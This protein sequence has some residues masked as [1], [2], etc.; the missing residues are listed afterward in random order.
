MHRINE[1]RLNSNILDWNFIP[2]K[3]NIS[4]ICTRPLKI[5]EFLNNRYYLTGPN[6]LHE[7]ISFELNDSKIS[8]DE[9]KIEKI[10]QV[11]YTSNTVFKPIISWQNYSSWIKLI[12]YVSC[13]K[14]VVRRWLNVKRKVFPQIQR[15]VTSEIFNASVTV[16]LKLIQMESFSNELSILLCNSSLKS[17]NK[18]LPLN[19]IINNDLI[20]VGGRLNRSRDLPESS[21]HQIILPTYHYVTQL[22]IKY[23]HESNHHCGRDQ[24]LS[25]VR[26]NYWIINAKSVIRKVLSDCLYCKRLRVKPNPQFMSSL[27]LER[28]AIHQPP[29]THTGIDYFGPI[30][31]KKHR[32][33]RSTQAEIK[34]YGA[35]FTCLTTRAV[36]LE[37][38]GDMSTDSFLLTLR[39][40]IA[41]RG[42]PQTIYSDNGTNF[43]GAE[44]ELKKALKLLNQS[45]VNNYLLERNIKWKFNPPSSPWMG[46]A[47]ESIVKLAKRAL[48]TVTNSRAIYDEN[49]VTFFTEVEATL[50][51]RPLVSI[52]DDVN[53]FNVLT[54]NSFIL[55]TSTSI[56]RTSDS[57]DSELSCRQRWKAVEA[58]T[59]MFWRRF[60]REYVPTLQCRRK[61]NK[62]QRNFQVNDIV[63]IQ[64]DDISRSF[65][66]LARI[67]EVF[68]GKDGII[69]S[70][71]LKTSNSILVR[72]SNRICLLEE[73]Q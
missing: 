15:K 41:R 50:N 11:H 40:F 21:K 68:P 19:P 33:T 73:A 12:R 4:D 3:Y 60:V 26:L 1:I 10:L 54:P 66:P 32:K 17:N 43:V 70:V 71:K 61:W 16:V 57:K 7:N 69:R 47:W 20:K 42:K 59:N 46:G 29:F 30:L 14:L 8:D 35:L 67:I 9:R 38:A 27:P 37:V 63:I 51:S 18:M 39:R 55:G 23:I 44:V 45:N 65:W 53:D 48:K 28:L 24:T 52:S 64:S 31:I 25:F 49:L 56:F 62:V 34:R 6:L 58:L 36:H 72:P 5:N 22:I 2:G 13:I